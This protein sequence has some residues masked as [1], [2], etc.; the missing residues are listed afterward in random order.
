MVGSGLFYDARGDIDAQH[1]APG[2]QVGKVPGD[3]S[4]AATHIE[5]SEVWS[6]VR[7]EVGGILF[8]SAVVIKRRHLWV[9]T[10][11]GIVLIRHYSVEWLSNIAN[12]DGWCPW[13]SDNMSDCRFNIDALRAT[14][15][16]PSKDRYRL[17]LE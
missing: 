13:L 4:G 2:N 12:I 8:G 16:L 15:N 6:Q 1:S 11:E 5:D 7:E 9:V 3:A 17:L 10:R 14:P